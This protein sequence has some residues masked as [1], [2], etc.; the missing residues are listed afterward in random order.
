M[1]STYK[2]QNLIFVYSVRVNLVF[3]FADVQVIHQTLYRRVAKHVV[4]STCDVKAF[5]HFRVGL[6]GGIIVLL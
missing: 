5:V 2:L 4:G 3:F 1:E 6:K